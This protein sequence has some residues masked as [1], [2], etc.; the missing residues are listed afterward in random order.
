MKSAHNAC[1]T[2]RLVPSTNQPSPSRS[3]R[4]G[5]VGEVGSGLQLGERDGADPLAGR[6]LPTQLQPVLGVRAVATGAVAAGDDAAHAHPGSGQLLGDQ[7][8]LE[9]PE[10]EPALVLVRDQYPEVAE[11]PD[12][13]EEDLRDVLMSW[14]ERVGGREHLVHREGACRPLELQGF[15]VRYSLAAGATVCTGSRLWR[16]QVVIGQVCRT[17]SARGGTQPRTRRNSTANEADLNER[18]RVSGCRR[19]GWPRSACR[20]R[21]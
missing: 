12:P 14:V 17:A 21:C 2:Q 3:T 6:T 16:C 5:D 19:P 4:A 9:H 1:P 7:A 11:L 13:V 18:G 10:T 15:G 20:P 8:V